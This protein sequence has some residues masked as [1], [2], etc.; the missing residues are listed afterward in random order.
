MQNMMGGKLTKMEEVEDVVV[1]TVKG[2]MVAEGSSGNVP[3]DYTVI[4]LGDVVEDAKAMNKSKGSDGDSSA[5]TIRPGDSLDGTVGVE[6]AANVLLQAVT[7]QPNARNSTMSVTGGMTTTADSVDDD[8]VVWEDSFLR[9]DGP[10]LWRMEEEGVWVKGDGVDRAFTALTTY[11]GEWSVIFDN[12]AKGTGLTTPVRVVPTKLRVAQEK[13]ES[14]SIR[15]QWSVRLEFKATSTGSSYKSKSEERQYERQ[16]STPSSNDSSSSSSS[17]EPVV[18]N[19]RQ[20]REGG[21]EMLVEKT[22]GTDG[23]MG[24]RVRARR[25]N[26]DDFT[27]VKEI[28]EETIVKK[29]QEAVGVWKK[30]FGQ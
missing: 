10:E 2:R 8:F 1:S 17:K 30:Q 20:T 9:L 13:E 26:M 29:I 5:M 12:G 28:S 21:V 6:A 22:R 3:L 27:V 14:S 25:C 16:R 4:K 23:T 18:I 7:M 15:A 19:N 11:L 24:I